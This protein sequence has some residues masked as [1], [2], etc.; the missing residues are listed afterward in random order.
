M[1]RVFGMIHDTQL[2]CCD[3]NSTVSLTGWY[4]SALR[5]ISHLLVF[6]CPSNFIPGIF[7]GLL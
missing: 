7:Y 1:F 5:I 4:V 6:F 3:N 2:V